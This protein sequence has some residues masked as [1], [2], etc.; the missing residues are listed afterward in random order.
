MLR[1]SRRFEAA[2]PERIG[3]HGHARDRHRGGRP[4]R[5]Q[6]PH[7]GQRDHHDV[8]GEGPEQVL[9]G[10]PCTC[11]G[12]G[13]ARR[14]PAREPRTE[15]VHIGRG[16]RHVG[17]RPDRH[18]DGRAA[19]AGASFRPSPT[20][21]TRAPAASSARTSSTLSPGQDLRRPIGVDADRRCDRPRGRRPVARTTIRTRTP[22]SRSRPIAAG[23]VGLDPVAHREQPH[24]SPSRTTAATCPLAPPR[25]R[26]RRA[27]GPEARPGVRPTGGVADR[28][29]AP[30]PASTRKSRASGT[31]RPR[32]ARTAPR[33]RARWGVRSRPRPPRPARGHR[34]ARRPRLPARPR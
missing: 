6:H 30:I 24:T 29:V 19:S 22:A 8:V 27:S 18:A 2:E 20:N 9:L 4:H 7:H 10:S 5:V 13:R 26:R 25:R 16:K 31:T 17:P 23:R 15:Q 12:Q 1:T 28:A 14:G 32:S 21:A 34:R 11:A 33:R 3:H